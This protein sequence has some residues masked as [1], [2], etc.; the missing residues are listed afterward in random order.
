MN[1]HDLGVITPIKKKKTP[2]E[3]PISSWDLSLKPGSMLT[4]DRG[5]QK[6]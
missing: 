2:Y 1:M 6:A 4:L 5:P 3:K